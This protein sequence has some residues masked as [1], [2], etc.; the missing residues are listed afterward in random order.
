MVREIG[1]AECIWLAGS[2]WTIDFPFDVLYT[3]QKWVDK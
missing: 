3:T 2:R 1:T